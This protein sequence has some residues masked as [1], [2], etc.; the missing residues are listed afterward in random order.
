MTF[1][2]TTG[3]LVKAGLVKPCPIDVQAITKLI[4][5]AYLDLRTA[6]RNLPCE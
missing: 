5:R 1:K 4:R 6:K 2:E 3:H